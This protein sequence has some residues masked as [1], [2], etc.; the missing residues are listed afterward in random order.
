MNQDTFSLIPRRHLSR[1]VV[2]QINLVAG[3]LFDNQAIHLDFSH[4]VLAPDF[5]D[6]LVEISLTHLGVETKGYL[7][8]KEVERLLGLPV[9]H[10]DK[11]YLSYLI[12]QNLAE[13]GVQYVSFVTRENVESLPALM[14]CVFVCQ[15][16]K[17]T[18]Y[19]NVESLDV[20]AEY[21][22]AKAQSLSGNLKLSVSWSPFETYLSSDELTAL[23]SDDVVLVYPK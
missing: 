19:L 12:A 13:Y 8:L 21:L 10:L 22:E 7:R 11:E 16:I 23:S 15:R 3:H 1:E 17:T 20:D 4:L 6:E 9:K 5:D 2:A 18:L 14:A